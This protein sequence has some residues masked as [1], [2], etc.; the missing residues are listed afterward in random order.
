MIAFPSVAGNLTANDENERRDIFLHNRVTGITKRAPSPWS[1]AKDYLGS[2]WPALS[3]TGSHLAYT[4]RRETSFGASHGREESLLVYHPASGEMREMTRAEYSSLAG[5][6]ALQA[7]LNGQSLA[8]VVEKTTAEGNISRGIAVVNLITG[9]SDFLNSGYGLGPDLILGTEKPAFSER[10]QV[11]A[12]TA[13][14]REQPEI[15]APKPGLFVLNYGENAAGQFNISG[16]VIDSTGSPL[17]STTVSLRSG[18]STLTDHEG[19]FFFSGLTA[20][21]HKLTF[22]KEGYLFSPEEISHNVDGDISD[23]RVIGRSEELLEEARK[24][25][26][27]PYSFHRGCE[28]ELQGCGGP[29]HGFAAGYCTD[30]ILDAYRWGVDFN[31]QFALERDAL[32]N[33]DH[34]YRWRNARNSH[35]MWRYFHYTGQMLTNDQPYQPGD[36][37]FFDWDD[38]SVIDHVSLLSEID[39]RG[40]P[41]KMIDATGEIA[42]NPSGLAAELDW[43]IFHAGTITGHARWFG[44]YGATRPATPPSLQVLQI[45][46]DSR[47]VTA[48]LYDSQGNVLTGPASLG[49]MIPGGSSYDQGLGTVLSVLSP[50]SNGNTYLLELRGRMDGAYN[51]QIQTLEGG[52]VT[53]YVANNQQPLM[54]DEVKFIGI[55][56]NE[57]QGRLDLIVVNLH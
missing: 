14:D 5:P 53:K 42:Y 4:A 16:Q 28:T 50:L 11:F 29:Y 9:V 54:E 35:D 30:L 20:G 12:F 22:Q 52:L 1:G 51:L 31:L 7:V 45:A 47:S 2:D 3:A 24:D 18:K 10:A 26:G 44:S 19:F 36:I 33:P 49:K 57:L 6:G 39:S 8:Y 41:K 34:F 40:R 37:L 15:E 21:D 23:I 43:E 38:D 56:V 46:V 17:R 13:R 48:S 55:Q 25:I 27:M 32:A